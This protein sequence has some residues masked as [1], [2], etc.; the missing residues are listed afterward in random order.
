MQIP[1]FVGNKDAAKEGDAVPANNSS[2]NQ[3]ELALL[4]FPEHEVYLDLG[5]YVGDYH[6]RVFYEN[7]Q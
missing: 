5:V 7:P 1:F 3:V 6:V 2:N 4:T